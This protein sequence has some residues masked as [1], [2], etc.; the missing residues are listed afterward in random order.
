MLD[1]IKGLHLEL[2]NHCTLKCPYCSRTT[3]LETFKHKNWTNKQI[4]LQDL[5]NFIDIDMSGKLFLLC[6]NDGDPIY[7]DQLF[8][9][10]RWIKDNNGLIQIHTN[11]SYR[12]QDWWSE[13]AE[14]LTADDTITFGIDGMPDNFTQH[15]INADWSSMLVGIKTM[16][17]SPAKVI[18][19]Y[20]PFSYNLDSLEPAR[21]LSQDLGFDSFELLYS[22]RWRSD[23]DPLKPAIDNPGSRYEKIVEWKQGKGKDIEIDPLCKTTHEE[24]FITA[25][26]YYTPCC[27]TANYKFYYSSDF[28]KNRKD[29]A[30][31]TT[32][33]T[34]VLSKLA[35]FYDTIEAVKPKFCSFN[36]PK[37]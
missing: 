23:N 27:N 5:Q 12:K 35:D 18:W 29:Y 20:I 3:F 21:Q 34:T 30:I 36:C 14:T 25:D 31:S 8:E 16:V 28:Y 9:L 22:D 2:T 37:L 7:Y 13:L 33:L 19:K 26:G 10:A 24:H 6:G 32:R 17:A 15:R 11:G 4:D 1:T